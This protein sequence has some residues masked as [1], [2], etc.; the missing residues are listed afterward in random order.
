MRARF[1]TTGRPASD[2]LASLREMKADDADWRGGRVP[3][4]VFKAS[5]AVDELGKAAFMEFFSENALG[6]RRAFTSL[7]RMEDEVLGMALDL[8]HAPDEAVGAMTT[9]GTESVIQALQACRDWN[10]ARR[11][12]PHHRGNIVLP[13]TAH[14]AFDK[15]ARLMDIE[16]RR[17]PTGPDLRADAARMAAAIDADTIM[18]VGSAP[19]FPFGLI[20]P[21]AALS[22]LALA[23]D[24][25]LHVDACVGGYLAPFVRRLGHAIPDFDFAL[26]GVSSLSADLHKFGFCPKPASTVFY[27]NADKGGHN[28]FDLDVWPSGRFRTGTIVGTRPGGGVAAAWATLTHL[29]EA[30]Y[31]EI[32]RQLMAMMA[33]YRAGIE[34]IPGLQIHGDPPLT[35]LAFGADDIDIFAVAEAMAGRGWL[36]GLTQRPKGIHRMMSMIHAGTLDAYLGD[37]AACV[38]EIRARA[39]LP[40][41][42]L[43]ASY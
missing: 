21:I 22:D 5:D 10:R 32:A 36:P 27:R 3:L 19:C 28:G 43:T 37:L 33:R 40:E 39:A 2:V 14:P 11:R 4:Y 7:K 9:G 42:R 25:W 20:D 13:E 29:G 35:L 8:F 31:V 34:A 15:G 17:V 12:D 1:P 26:P 23:R 6:A 41:S 24:V 18:L 30:G 38:G 16:V